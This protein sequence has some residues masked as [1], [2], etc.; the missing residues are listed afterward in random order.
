MSGS[1]LDPKLAQLSARVEAL[2]LGLK[3][4]LLLFLILTTVGDFAAI[5]SIEKYRQLFIQTLPGKA[6]PD[7]TLVVLK[8]VPILHLVAFLWPLIG[9]VALFI[10]K[11]VALAI[12]LFCGAI[13]CSILQS[14]LIFLA[15]R[16]PVQSVM[17][18]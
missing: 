11:N 7:L 8:T 6:L 15:L 17:G 18:G 5:A 4:F 1:D 13:A 16:L 14:S 10:R 3:V 2:F 9:V 12:F